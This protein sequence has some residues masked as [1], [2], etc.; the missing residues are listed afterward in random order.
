M[1]GNFSY[2]SH[3]KTFASLA[4]QHLFLS[5]TFLPWVFIKSQVVHY[6]TNMV[7]RGNTQIK[8]SLFYTDNN[9]AHLYLTTQWANNLTQLVS[10]I[11]TQCPRPP[12]LVWFLI[13][14]YHVSYWAH[15]YVSPRVGL[16]QCEWGRFR[17]ANINKIICLYS[18]FQAMRA[19]LRANVIFGHNNKHK[20][21]SFLFMDLK[22]MH[23]EWQYR[24]WRT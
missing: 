7:Y 15:L 6:C 3:P 23:N 17:S 9:K 10:N 4:T 8:I 5:C 12:H 11:I 16:R 1:F 24:C 22:C 2:S 20:Q 14:M 19:S 21:P 13:Y 18:M